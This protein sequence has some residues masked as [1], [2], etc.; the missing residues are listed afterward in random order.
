MQISI[1]NVSI[2]ALRGQRVRS[3]FAYLVLHADRAVSR[4]ELAGNLWPDVSETQARTNLRRELHTLKNSH[5][6]F[7]A[8]IS[9]SKHTVTWRMPPYYTLDTEEFDRLCQ[10]FSAEQDSVQKSNLGL[11]AVALYQDPLLSGIA[12][13]WLLVKREALHQQWNLLSESLIGLLQ[14][15]DVSEQII[16]IATR[17]LSFDPYLETSYLAIMEAY[18]ASGNSAMALH[19]YHQCAS[20]LKK[21]LGVT[22]NVHIQNLYAQLISKNSL[23]DK[24]QYVGSE[25]V[26]PK[27]SL[28]LIGRSETLNELTEIIKNSCEG[29]PRI[30]LITGESGIGKSRLA[31]EVLHAE[32]LKNFI[33]VSSECHP[34]RTET[35]FGPFKDWTMDTRL[36]SACRHVSDI[37]NETIQQMFPQLSPYVTQ[38]ICRK[39]RQ[40]HSQEAIFAA[41]SNIIYS[42]STF[43]R[44]DQQA[45][46]LLYIDDIQWADNDFFNWL[47]YFLVNQKNANIV[48]LATARTEELD[49][50]NNISGF[51]KDFG[52]SKQASVIQLPYLNRMESCELINRQLVNVPSLDTEQIDP[53]QIYNM[54]Q[55]NPLFLIESVNHLRTEYLPNMSNE[56]KTG[57]APWIYNMLQ[58]RVD[59]LMENSRYLLLLASVVQRQFSL[60]LIQALTRFE[61]SELMDALDDLWSKG[62]LR[63]VNQGD[64]DFA[65]D[66]LREACYSAL[67]APRRRMLHGQVAKTLENLNPLQLENLAG[68]IAIHHEK[69]GHTQAAIEWFERALQHANDSLAAAS[70]IEY[71]KRCLQLIDMTLPVADRADIQVKILLRL[72]VGYAIRGGF[73]SRDLIP[74]NREIEKLLPYVSDPETRWGAVYRLRLTATF[75][76]QTYH[77]LRLTEVQLSSA[78]NTGSVS[79]IIDAH[80]SRSFVLYQLGRFSESLCCLETG[81]KIA[82]AAEAAGKL[83]RYR[84]SW[85][86]VMLSKIRIQALYLVGRFNDALLENQAGYQYQH[87]VGTPHSRSLV[88]MWD[89]ENALVRNRP[90]DA[91]RIGEEMVKVG[92]EELLVQVEYLGRFFCNWATCRQNNTTAAID[93]LKHTIATY[94]T[95]ETNISL[96]LWYHSLAEI[97]Y[98]AL[99]LDEAL[100][101]NSKAIQAVRHTR[102]FNRKADIYRVRANI[103]AAQN[104]DQAKVIRLYDFS[105]KTAL[106]QSAQLYVIKTL[107]DKLIFLRK[108]ELPTQADARQLQQAVNSVQKSSDFTPLQV[109]ERL[110]TEILSE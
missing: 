76:Y 21:E 50:I 41:L 30:V 25:E 48:F 3:I 56:D 16:N 37:A 9:A 24:H 10:D 108:Q 17:Q 55:G 26:T 2:D 53:D 63:E 34:A 32:S 104:S 20:V 75:S 58:R 105:L 107:I 61:D 36:G 95:L 12:D 47:R 46:L 11:Q 99:Q 83:D 86:L 84:P 89:A 66:S 14:H 29:L 78:N 49:V 97:Q 85:P 15:F 35:A 92:Q 5:S 54:V 40:L 110:L 45:R 52:F 94:E 43:Y 38:T 27:E 31:D 93:K 101:S 100:H 4:S 23:N 102:V 71:G 44:N 59:L 8:C 42:A 98:S 90:P 77:A 65:H 13:E 28:T 106:K 87:S 6:A 62:M 70:S 73:G 88:Y 91:G 57:T 33:V 68:E 69:S 39:N 82:R 18:V 64:Y 60:S 80:K 7:N 109:A 19:T 103:L 1:D 96:A 67:A 51:I 74:A 22:P 81:L 72:S 79:N